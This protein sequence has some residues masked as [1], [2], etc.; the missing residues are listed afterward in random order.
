MNIVIID[1]KVLSELLS[2]LFISRPCV[3]MRAC[4]YIIYTSV[5]VTYLAEERPT[6]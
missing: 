5:A 6:Y 3:D 1:F 2:F 4:V